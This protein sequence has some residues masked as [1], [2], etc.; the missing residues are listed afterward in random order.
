MDFRV[1]PS[2]PGHGIEADR[3]TLGQVR[4]GE[5]GDFWGERHGWASQGAVFEIK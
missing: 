3:F 5:S 4:G 1:V 2:P